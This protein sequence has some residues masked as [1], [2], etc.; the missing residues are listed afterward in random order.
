MR[1]GFPEQ[2]HPSYLGQLVQ[3]IHRAHE[4]PARVFIHHQ[5][6][7][8]ARPSPVLG[9]ERPHHIVTRAVPETRRQSSQNDQQW[10]PH[11]A[12]QR[13]RGNFVES[14]V[15]AVFCPLI[16]V[17]RLSNIILF[18]C[19]CKMFLYNAGFRTLFL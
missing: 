16:F 2:P 7:E 10:G 15:V 3:L 13:R 1:N 19:L 4:H 18:L 12:R 17:A 9:T 8:S 11:D 6:I 14:A 5:M